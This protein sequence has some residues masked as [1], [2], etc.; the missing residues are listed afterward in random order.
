MQSIRTRQLR[1]DLS[2]DGSK[3]TASKPWAFPAA[4][5]LGGQTLASSAHAH[6]DSYC[7][8]DVA[9]AAETYTE[10]G[11]GIAPYRSLSGAIAE[12][13]T[14]AN[15]DTVVFKLA[16]GDYIGT[17]LS[18]QN[19]QNQ[20]FSIVGSG[21]DN[22][23]IK[24]SAAWDATVGNV[25]YF[26]KY[27][28]TSFSDLTVQYG[29]YGIYVKTANSCTIQNC[30]FQFLGS[31]GF[32]HSFATS[33]TALTALWAARGTAGA[34]RSDGGTMR[35]RAVLEVKINGCQTIS[36]LRGYRIQDCDFGTI[37]NCTAREL[38]ESAYYLASGT[39]NNDAGCSN[40]QISGCSACDIFHQ[41]F[42]VVG[43]AH[44]TIQG[45]S[46]TRCAN[47]GVVGWDTSD[48]KVLAN[49]FD[50]CNTKSYRG[51]GGTGDSYSQVFQ[52]NK[53]NMVDTGGY[54]L[55][56]LNNIFTRCGQGR[57][58]AVYTFFF[59]E[60]W[61]ETIASFRAIIDG[62]SSD[63][64]AIISNDGNVPLISTAIPV[65]AGG[66]LSG[67]TINRVMVT[68][69]SGDAT[70]SAVTAATLAFVDPTSSVQTQL[71]A[72]AQ[73]DSA[74]TFTGQVKTP[75]LYVYSPG[76][77]DA[78][79]MMQN[80]GTNT[81]KCEHRGGNVR[82]KINQTKFYMHDS[83]RHVFEGTFVVMPH[84]ASQSASAAN[85]KGGLYLDTSTTPPLLKYHDGVQWLTVA[86]V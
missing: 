5:T 37:T 56:C 24:G 12:K 33:D 1:A 65:A 14:H 78:M 47:G 73:L 50:Q 4:T 74:P 18:I 82:M 71:D 13:L 63:A 45:C 46:A 51:V 21:R 62:N 19:T 69:G 32:D 72:S 35:I 34:H 44:N 79:F 36:C 83:G 8:V 39:Y 42:L 76:G 48:L 17:I 43:G 58:D 68:D 85:S 75:Q 23:F 7:Y 9:R 59:L 16:P 29:A 26:E 52:H 31:D 40:F 84:V 66:G 38:L 77:N 2:Y 81:W 80:S 27:L 53:D 11:S 61:D 3:Y 22:T 86:T 30:N 70:T 54:A 60:D 64:A 25:L 57:A 55:T 28:F 10:T 15:T 49:T 41:P 20:S 67:A 6:V